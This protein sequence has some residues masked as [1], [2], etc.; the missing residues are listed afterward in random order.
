MASGRDLCLS[1]SMN[2]YLSK[3][4]VAPTLATVLAEFHDRMQPFVLA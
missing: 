2:V 4:V 3:S 1:S